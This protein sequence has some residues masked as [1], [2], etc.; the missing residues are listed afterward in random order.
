MSRAE[1]NS[2]SILST[3]RTANLVVA[4]VTTLCAAWFLTTPAATASAQESGSAVLPPIESIDAQTD[5]TGF[6]QSS[7]PTELRLAALRRAWSADPAI[8]DFVGLQENGWN[9]NDPDSILGFGEI[10][11]E[12]DVKTMLAA[13]FGEPKRSAARPSRQQRALFG[14]ALPLFW[15]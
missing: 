3:K 12:V 10:G 9:F 6:L 5:I 4:A 14:M 11:P 8:R 1:I 7:V 15:N 2:R 13:I